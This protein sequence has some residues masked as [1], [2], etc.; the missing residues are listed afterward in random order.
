MVCVL[1]DWKFLWSS[2]LCVDFG[3]V[4]FWSSAYVVSWSL[5]CKNWMRN[6]NRCDFVM[7]SNR[8]FCKFSLLGCM[9]HCKNFV[10]D[11]D[12]LWSIMVHIAAST[13][14]WR[15][16]KQRCASRRLNF[17]N[18]L[19]IK[20]QFLS[21]CV[22]CFCTVVNGGSAHMVFCGRGDSIASAW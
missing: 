19:S 11:L 3:L 5:V 15:A 20:F 13:F 12:I 7:K 10:N 17:W 2:L 4:N 18:C 9:N 14:E 16:W 22:R 1:L 8:K 6:V 21:F